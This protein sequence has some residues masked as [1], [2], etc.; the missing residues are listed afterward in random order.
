ML[1]GTGAKSTNTAPNHTICTAEAEGAAH[2]TGWFGRLVAFHS[3]HAMCAMSCYGI[4]LSTHALESR[5]I[6]SNQIKSSELTRKLSLLVGAVPF[7]AHTYTHTHAQDVKCSKL[8]VHVF[9]CYQVSFSVV[10]QVI[11]KKK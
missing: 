4:L 2:Q 11:V 6:K 8:H 1:A 5:R 9:I 3:I 7:F 10:I